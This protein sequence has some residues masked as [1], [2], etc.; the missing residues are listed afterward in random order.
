MPETISSNIITSATVSIITC[1]LTLA[2]KNFLERKLYTF[3]LRSNHDYEQ[4]S[5]IK[6][7]IS[8]YKIRILETG[9]SLN[10]RLWNFS[11]NCKEGWHISKDDDIHDKKYY[12]HSF[13]YRFLCFF[14]YCKKLENEMIYLDSTISESNDLEFI[15]YLKLFPQIFC[16]TDLFEGK[17]YDVSEPKDHFFKNDFLEIIDMMICPDGIITY[18]EFKSQLNSGKHQKIVTYISTISQDKTCLKWHTMNLFHFILMAFLTKYGYD[19]QQT[20]KLKLKYLAEQNPRNGLITNIS[21][22]LNR[23]RL[24]KSAE[25]K[26]VIKVLKANKN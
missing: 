8:K 6:K 14:A 20:P 26:S 21:K 16:D 25:L 11:N 18:T 23:N 17:K 1:L 24:N 13:C 19:F 10:H 2:L 4:R 9:E 7:I 12:Q 5:Q 22:I 3:K 15:K